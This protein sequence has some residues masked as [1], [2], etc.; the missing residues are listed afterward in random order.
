MYIYFKY[1]K[2]CN[3]C[4]HLVQ[5]AKS[6][7]KKEILIFQKIFI[8]K[9]VFKILQENAIECEQLSQLLR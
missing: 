4:A 6:K 1:Q 3:L 7:Y 2:D 8:E 9:F 5:N